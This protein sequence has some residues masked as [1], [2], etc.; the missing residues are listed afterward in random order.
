MRPTRARLGAFARAAALRAGAVG[1]LGAC[2][3][4]RPPPSLLLAA[5]GTIQGDITVAAQASGPSPFVALP[6][7]PHVGF[8][9]HDWAL[10]PD[11]AIRT[12][13][14][15]NADVGLRLGASGARVSSRVGLS[16]SGSVGLA[17]EPWVA[18]SAR[19][20]RV[21]GPFGFIGWGGCAFAEVGA[22]FLLTADLSSDL[23]LHVGPTAALRVEVDCGRRTPLI[24]GA[25]GA[26]GVQVIPGFRIAVGL[27]A[28]TDLLSIGGRDAG[29]RAYAIAQLAFSSSP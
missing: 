9:T 23:G 15:P 21:D 2:A 11:I 27:S 25:T 3:G 7:A 29:E 14:S 22:P 17:S 5:P 18:I 19:S 12:G 6:V 16:R 10:A 8:G 20:F 24:V 1:L 26:L 13:I 28:G 4:A